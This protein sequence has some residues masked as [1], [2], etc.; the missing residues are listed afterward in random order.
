MLTDGP[1]GGL[2]ERGGTCMSAEAGGGMYR[3][4]HVSKQWQERPLQ[5]MRIE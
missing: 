1:V 5:W 4:S 2:E 3:Q